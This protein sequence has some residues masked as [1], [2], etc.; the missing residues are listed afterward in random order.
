MP[1]RR[2]EEMYGSPVVLMAAVEGGGIRAAFPG[3]TG[4]VL[5][6]HPVDAAG[7]LMGKERVTT[8]EAE[9]DSS[10][11]VCEFSDVFCFSEVSGCVT[12]CGGV[13]RGGVG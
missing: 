12:G 7:R 4:V 9:F 8:G 5:V 3:V 10:E 2:R 11:D 13:W 6:I 1:L